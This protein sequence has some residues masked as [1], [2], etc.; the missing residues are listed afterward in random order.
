M[1]SPT[2]PA[3]VAGSPALGADPA[4]VPSTTGGDLPPTPE[5]EPAAT[6]EVAADAPPVEH[7]AVVAYTDAEGRVHYA[8][9][10]AKGTTAKVAAGVWTEHAVDAFD[11]TTHL[12]REVVAHLE[13]HAGNAAEVARVKA[14][15]LRPTVQAWAPQE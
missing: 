12:V 14:A 6:A 9:P 1:T 8:S 10:T 15:D 2:V 13:A 5:P 7:R 4:P 11:P 3:D